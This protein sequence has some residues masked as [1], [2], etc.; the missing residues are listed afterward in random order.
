M[1]KKSLI[2]HFR[3]SLRNQEKSREIFMSFLWYLLY[4]RIG[5]KEV[6][7]LGNTLKTPTNQA[8]N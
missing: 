6:W 8:T 1:H 3:E 2:V 7:Q 4:D 5:L